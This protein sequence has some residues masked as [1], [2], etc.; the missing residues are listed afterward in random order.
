MNDKQVLH[1]I[2]IDD[3]YHV[4]RVLSNGASGTTELVTIDGAGP[5]VRKK[6]AIE[7]ANPVVW[8]LI[9]ALDCA[10]LPK[11]EATYSL[12][13]K[14]VVVYDY[15]PGQTLEELV[16]GKGRLEAEEAVSLVT[17]I[18]EA[19][20]ALHSCDVIHRDLSPRN[21][22]VAA[23]GAHLIDLGIARR[24]VEGATRDTAFL[25]THGFA[26][27]EQY[28][29]A[30]TD[31]RSDVYAI[32]KLLGYML[33]GTEPDDNAY[34]LLLSN[35]AV[36]QPCLAACVQRACAFEP[37]A[38]YQST[39]QFASELR[40]A[41]SM[42]PSSFEGK[43]VTTDS[44]AAADASKAKTA[45]P[46]PKH[47]FPKRISALALIALMLLALALVFFVF[48]PRTAEMQNNDE[49]SGSSSSEV[50]DASDS[51]ATNGDAD[52]DAS[53]DEKTDASTPAS[54]EFPL[55][56]AES[57]WSVNSNGSVSYACGIKNTSEDLAVEL[58]AIQ[59]VGYD[60]DGSVLF[61]DENVLG[62]CAPGQMTYYAGQ[63]EGDDTKPTRVEFT[64]QKDSETDAIRLEDTVS[65]SASEVRAR[66]IDDDIMKF[67]G[68]VRIDGADEA[69]SKIKAI[70]SGGA[71]TIV[72]RDADGKIIAGYTT[73]I[74]TISTG[75][76]LPY[77][78]REY[79]VPAFSSAE[80]HVRPW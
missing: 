11:I 23:D 54:D 27:P 47:S 50:T 64:L 51:S 9:S 39:E 2:S 74:N 35:P 67:S 48:G 45:S 22:I 28:G 18:C 13:D 72:L 52:N 10:R 60:A 62:V 61:S 20:S 5:F 6:I 59:V 42:P 37:S 70:D 19:A 53:A 80:A 26:S 34:E 41:A 49:S 31:A 33:T 7:L 44:V 38:R 75:K 56:L 65:Y 71:V 36:V 69:L 8:S 46:K 21:V 66:K 3:V 17:D 16:V 58:P 63:A 55:E 4:E 14:Y 77:S 73:F 24:R 79:F 32:G 29:F 68:T 43:H 57:G 76:D 1:A 40:K 15:V 30:Q 78:L 25:G 12:P